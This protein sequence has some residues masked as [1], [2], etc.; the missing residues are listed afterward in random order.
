MVWSLLWF[1]LSNIH[2]H[3]LYTEMYHIWNVSPW[4]LK[5]W[6][7][8]IK[9]S[10][11]TLWIHKSRKGNQKNKIHL[12]IEYLNIYCFAQVL[13]PRYFLS[14]S[15]CLWKAKCFTGN[16]GEKALKN[17]P[18]I[19]GLNLFSFYFIHLHSMIN[20]LTD[21]EERKVIKIFINIIKEKRNKD[22]LS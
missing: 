11:A 21:S 12:S 17:I 15:P 22:D 3:T 1:M 20:H 19:Q 14:L 5:W 6:Y 8:H 10:K 13:I 16:G 7:I 2:R 9:Y 18:Q 4:T